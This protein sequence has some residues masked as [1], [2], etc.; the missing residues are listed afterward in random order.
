MLAAAARIIS[1]VEV[2]VTVDAEAGYG[3]Q[4]DMLVARL[5]QVGAAGCNLEDT[6]HTTGAQRDVRAHADWLQQVRE[7]ASAEDYGLVVNARIDT[8]LHAA[9]AAGAGGDQAQLVADA[10]SA[11][12]GI[13]RRAPTACFP[14]SCGSAA[15]LLP[16]PPS[17]PPRS[18][19][20]R[21][22]PRRRSP[23]SPS[24][25]WPASATAGSCTTT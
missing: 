25:A 3:L 23:P 4:P 21:S 15:R 16:S 5:K 11:H 7:A 13:W 2:P 19:S 1:S 9:T 24:W 18:T 22:R 17:S 12:R 10:S 8:F 14:S 20:W 6:D